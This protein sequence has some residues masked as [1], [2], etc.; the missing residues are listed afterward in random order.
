MWQCDPDTKRWGGRF[1]DYVAEWN[2][3]HELVIVPDL[4]QCLVDAKEY[5]TSNPSFDF[6]WT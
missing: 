1:I 6:I 5:A 2:S 3:S 4:S